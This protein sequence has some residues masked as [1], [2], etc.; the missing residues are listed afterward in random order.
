M[1]TA[2]VLSGGASLGAVQVGML[3]ALNDAGVAPDLLVGSSVGAINAA[4]IAAHRGP[5][6]VEALAEI[7]RG[8]RSSTVFPASPL[9]GAVAMLGRRNYLVSPVGWRP[10]SNSICLSGAWKRPG[11]PSMW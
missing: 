4:W 9:L 8:L 6:G 11:R 1:T 3:Q 7:W 2:F 10:C 5:E